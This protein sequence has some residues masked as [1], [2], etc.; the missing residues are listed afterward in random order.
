MN[1]LVQF[2]F[3]RRL[4][5]LAYFL[6][7]VTMDIGTAFL[8]ANNNMMNPRYFWFLLIGLLLYSLFY[9]LL[10][11]MRDIGMSG[12]WLIFLFIPVLNVVLGLILLF[13]APKYRLS[14][15]ND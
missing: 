3:P 5:R 8:Y 4:H 1:W 7:G 10:P 6:R 11:R 12:W 15:F 9:I 2:F 13:R 14:E